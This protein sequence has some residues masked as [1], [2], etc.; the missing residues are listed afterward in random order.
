MRS[1][2]RKSTPRVKRGRVQKKTN[3]SLTGDYYCIPQ[4][5]PA[6]DRR[7]PGPGYRHLLYRKDIYAFIQ[8]LPEWQ[9]LSRGLNAVVLAPG[10]WNTGGYIRVAGCR[11]RRV[12]LRLGA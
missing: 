5:L 2:Q 4:P 6:I 1:I 12:H 11:R 7:D 3:W 8:L 9:E 10:T